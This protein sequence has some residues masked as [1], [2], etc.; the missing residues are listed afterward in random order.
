[1]GAAES[2]RENEAAS[3]QTGRERPLLREAEQ[4]GSLW[5]PGS[6]RGKGGHFTEEIQ[7]GQGQVRKEN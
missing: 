2:L 5:G 4:A 7:A 6:A 3:E 1:M